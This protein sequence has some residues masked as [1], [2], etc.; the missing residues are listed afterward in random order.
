V[1]RHVR[2]RTEDGDGVSVADLARGE[3]T[4]GWMFHELQYVRVEA[5]AEAQLAYEAWC[6][7]PGRGGY[8]VYR[9]AQDR[10]DA[11]QDQLAAWVRR[12][13]GDPSEGCPWK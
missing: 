3:E 8:A 11:A 1:S 12:R 6:R 13:Q 9:A 5:Q 10:A 4:A 7:S 2:S